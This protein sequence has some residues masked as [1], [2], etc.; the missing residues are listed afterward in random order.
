MAGLVVL[1]TLC[2]F[3]R[4]LIITNF[5]TLILF[6]YIF[7]I[8]L[9]GKVG[10]SEPVLQLQFWRKNPLSLPSAVNHHAAELILAIQHWTV[11]LGGSR[12]VKPDFI[13][14]KF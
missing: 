9:L 3:F 10:V 12:E 8:A 2:V 7:W 13:P 6:I 1:A 4:L 14:K 5:F 11:R